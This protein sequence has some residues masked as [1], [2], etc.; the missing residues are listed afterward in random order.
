M[1]DKSF[2]LIT[3]LNT[4]M[5]SQFVEINRKLDNKA[6]KN[7]II[8]LE[9]DIIRL[10]NNFDLKADAL[11]DGYQQLSE[12]QAKIEES[13]QELHTKITNQD[14]QITVLKKAK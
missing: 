8:R 9:N 2:E 1:E 11:L 4:E 7:D 5:T 14:I 13:I 3:Q 12:G 10:E 6:D